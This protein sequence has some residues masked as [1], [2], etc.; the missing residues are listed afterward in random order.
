ML[1]PRTLTI[2]AALLFGFAVLAIPVYWGPSFLE[3]VSSYVVIAADAPQATS[4]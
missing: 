3:P 1:S 4:R 2:L